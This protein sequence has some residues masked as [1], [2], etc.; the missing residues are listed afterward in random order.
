MAL[1][2]YQNPKHR[3]HR[4]KLRSIIEPK[5]R[6]LVY[7]SQRN[8][9]CSTHRAK[10]AACLEPHQNRWGADSG[11]RHP[12]GTLT[13]VKQK[14]LASSKELLTKPIL[15]SKISLKYYLCD[16]C[17]KESRVVKKKDSKAGRVGVKQERRRASPP[18]VPP[19]RQ[20]QP[21]DN[22]F[23]LITLYGLPIAF[24]STQWQE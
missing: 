18:I 19:H 13:N 20:E 22:I 23:T 6:C 9:V 2:G 17:K 3:T 21:G 11:K 1:R 8:P 14:I 24:P 15:V 10:L 7:V 16:T 4:W 5:H 12:L